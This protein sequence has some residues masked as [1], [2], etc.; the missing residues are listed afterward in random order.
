MSEETTTPAPK[1]RVIVELQPDG[2]LVMEYYTNGQRSRD[3]LTLGFEAFEIKDQ[4]RNQAQHLATAAERK[5]AALAEAASRRHNQAWRY[6]ATNHGIE[7]ANRTVNGVNSSKL[8]ARVDAKPKPSDN[9]PTIKQM[10]DLL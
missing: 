1:P 6:V 3:T 4:L 7:F 10:L 8:N 2:T 9:Q 5:A